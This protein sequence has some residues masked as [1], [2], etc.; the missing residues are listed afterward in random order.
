MLGPRSPVLKLT[1]RQFI[2]VVFSPSI[3]DQEHHASLQL[4]MLGESQGLFLFY[5][6]LEKA[7][8]IKLSISHFHFE[9]K[10]ESPSL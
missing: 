2:Q 1:N 10:D 3:S 6:N 4:H 8:G 5:Y 7:N 9:T